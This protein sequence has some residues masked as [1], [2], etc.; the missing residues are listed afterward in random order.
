VLAADK[1]LYRMQQ[2]TN[3]RQ[4]WDAYILTAVVAEQVSDGNT[5]SLAV[6]VEPRDCM[7]C[8]AKAQQYA[9]TSVAAAAAGPQVEMFVV[10]TPQ[11]SDALHQELIQIEQDL[12]TEL[13]LHFKVGVAGYRTCSGHGRWQV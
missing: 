10:C 13:G 11:Q 4:W 12:F 2:F 7:H 1:G 8:V 3:M 6:C 5:Q 9:D